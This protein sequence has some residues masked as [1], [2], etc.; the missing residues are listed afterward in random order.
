MIGL[1]GLRLAGV[2]LHGGGINPDVFVRRDE[3][4]V[5]YDGYTLLY[6]I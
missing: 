3:Y 6:I 2:I 4:P 5:H 1:E